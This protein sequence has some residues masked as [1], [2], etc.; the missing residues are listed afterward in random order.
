VLCCAVLCANSC[1]FVCAHAPQMAAR[2]GGSGPTT[3]AAAGKGAAALTSVLSAGS[4]VA[5]GGGGVE[6][7]SKR[8]VVHLK[9]VFVGARGVG[10]TALLTRFMKSYYSEKSVPTI[11]WDVHSQTISAFKLKA[12]L[13]AAPFP[14]SRCSC[15]NPFRYS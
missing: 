5:G 2:A 6:V 7:E 9:M 14:P 15:A 11:G 8:M 12:S 3:P 10:K 13:C 1:A 4:G